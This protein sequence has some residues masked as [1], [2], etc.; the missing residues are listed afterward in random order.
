[1]RF[2][3]A[4]AVV[5]THVELLKGQYGKPNL[6]QSNKL[7]FEL[8]ALGV[9]FFFVLSGFLITYLL[10][11]EK[12]TTNTIN[13][14]KFYLR[15]IL[16]IWP[17]YFLIFVAG[18]FILPKIHVL[19]HGYLSNY[20]HENFIQNILLYLIMLPN[21]ALALF[22]PVP[23]IGQL[24]SIGVEEQF[25]A[26]WPWLVKYSRNLLNV[27]IGVIVVCLLTKL[28][29]QFYFMSNPSNETLLKIKTFIATL[30]FESMAIGGIGAWCVHN[31]K[32]YSFFINKALTLISI[33]LVLLSVY[34]TPHALQD[35]LFLIQSVLFIIVIINVS[36][37]GSI[38]NKLENKLFVFLGNISYGIYMYH[39]IVIAFV[40]YIMNATGLIISNEFSSQIIIYSMT[41][42]ITIL[43]SWISYNYFE[44]YFIRLK[45]KATIINSGSND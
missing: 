10:L 38:T 16:R 35:G 20:L 21:L 19:D 30:K 39:M 13:I 4:L 26:I 6:W 45:K 1:M 12:T 37:S 8:G 3:A 5:I 17:L 41:V 7:I 24:W 27:L 18:F 33:V 43:L 32:Y 40:I 2:F 29:F 42:G 36:C 14:K 34:F 23:H 28:F 11:E 44:S 15:R 25:Y 22:K 31:K 9:V